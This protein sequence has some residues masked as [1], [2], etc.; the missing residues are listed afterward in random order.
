MNKSGQVLFY[1]LMLSACLLV[2][3]LAFATPIKQVISDT[4]NQMNCT[5]DSIDDQTKA[6]CYGY[7]ILM[8]FTIIL[9]IVIA[10]VVLGAKVIGG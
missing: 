7:E 10:F 9:F 2:L 1:T 6:S 3:A 4:T 8:W 5:S